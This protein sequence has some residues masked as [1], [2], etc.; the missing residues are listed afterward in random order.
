SCLFIMRD[1]FTSK[2]VNNYLELV[3]YALIGYLILVIIIMSI[4]QTGKN[5]TDNKLFLVKETIKRQ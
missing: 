2:N 1:I 3:V 4:I 5:I